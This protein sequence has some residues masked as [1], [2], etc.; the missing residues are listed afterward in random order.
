ME[1]Q[2]AGVFLCCQLWTIL[3]FLPA[4][5]EARIQSHWRTSEDTILNNTGIFCHILLRNDYGAWVKACRRN[6]CSESHGCAQSCGDL[7][8]RLSLFH[9]WGYT[10]AVADLPSVVM[11]ISNST[12]GV[13]QAGW[14][15]VWKSSG[16]VWEPK[17]GCPVLLSFHCYSGPSPTSS[18]TAVLT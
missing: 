17:V 9:C 5:C 18:D 11:T 10:A 4:I 6:P 1:S 14:S 7:I 3:H 16:C 13:R 12:S 8:Q 15:G 2:I